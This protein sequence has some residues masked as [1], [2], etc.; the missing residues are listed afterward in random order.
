MILFAFVFPLSLGGANAVLG[1]ILVLWI[2]EGNF[3]HKLEIVKNEKII[4]IFFTIGLLTLFSALFS[5]NMTHSFLAGEKKSL[6]RVISSHYIA[7]PLILTI[8]IT[9]IKYKYLDYIISAFL[10]AMLLS[11]IVSYL[12]FFQVVDVA[13]LQS[14]HLI[15]KLA[16]HL[17]PTP[18]LHHL[19]YSVF[20]SI[21][22]ILLLDKILHSKNRFLQFFLFLFLAS[23]T[24]NIFINGGRTGQ[25][26]YILAI[27]IYMLFYF[28]F[29]IKTIVLTITVLS[30]IIM[31]AY[32][33]SPTFKQRSH[34]ALQDIEKISQGNYSTSWG[35]RTALNIVTLDYLFSS[36]KNLI[37]GA[38]AGDSRQVFLDHAK[39]NF[40]TN[41]SKPVKTQPHLHNQYLEYWMD[42][43]VFSLLLLLFYFVLLL[44]LPVSTTTKP[45]LYAFVIII[46][47][48]SATDI[49][50]F[51]YQPAMLFY[52]L[53]AYFIVLSK[54][55]EQDIPE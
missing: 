38:G 37:L 39:K 10:L 15:Y 22:I 8:F 32:N 7:I 35:V 11:E 29:T 27:S 34:M 12:I 21:A 28:R 36:P 24:V 25:I 20:L 42:G 2:I 14:K 18:F 55:H 4:W 19:E 46:I 33:F 49:P 41:I 5:E 31:L 51:R 48:A 9:S 50:F 13:I 16:S 30:T 52:L 26:A 45:L 40:Q 17:N 47:F 1:L 44:K 53:S 54:K 43:T 3:K 6:I 23:A